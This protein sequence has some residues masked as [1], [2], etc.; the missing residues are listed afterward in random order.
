MIASKTAWEELNKERQREK[1]T[2]RQQQVVSF[3][4][5]GETTIGTALALKLSPKTIE[6]HRRK[7]LD[8]LGLRD[9][10]TLTKWAL[11]NGLTTL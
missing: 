8:R 5:G 1:L 2:P 7:A 6:Y 3:I 10:I 4:T 11:R 9:V